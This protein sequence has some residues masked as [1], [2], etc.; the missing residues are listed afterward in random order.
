MDKPLTLPSGT[1][2]V[3]EL[4]E[5]IFKRATA[6]GVQ[7]D[8]V[9]NNLTCNING[10]IRSVCMIPPGSWELIGKGNEITETVWRGIVEWSYDDDGDGNVFTNVKNY[11]TDEWNCDTFTESGLSLI[12]SLGYTPLTSV[13]IKLRTA[14]GR[15]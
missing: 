6:I 7:E 2:L 11:E 1:Y 9:S 5:D 13:L 15:T 8:M 4:P 10:N 3:I 14:S 12:K